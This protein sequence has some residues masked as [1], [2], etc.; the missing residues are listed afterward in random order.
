MKIKE[1]VLSD[2]EVIRLNLPK[3]ATFTDATLGYEKIFYR[4]KKEIDDIGTNLKIDLIPEEIPENWMPE[5]IND[6]EE[7]I[8]YIHLRNNK[9]VN[10]D[11]TQI[12]DIIEY[13]ING[14][15]MV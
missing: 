7:S 2:A 4:A 10:R 3:V 1:K 15:E 13:D 11:G 6:K 8:T 5:D 9:Q 12:E 14:Y